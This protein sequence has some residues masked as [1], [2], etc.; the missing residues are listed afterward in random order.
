M[1]KYF[2]MIIYWE[3]DGIFVC[4]IRNGVLWFI[5]KIKKVIAR[6]MGYFY[7]NI[8]VYLKLFL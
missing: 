1:R 2:V 4:K 8:C 6:D 3:V 7:A 5:F